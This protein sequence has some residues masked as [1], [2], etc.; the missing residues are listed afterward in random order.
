MLATTLGKQSLLTQK[1]LQ[2]IIHYSP[3]TGIFTWA[4]PRKGIAVT[5]K[6]GTLKPS[7]YIVILVK[8]K[9][10][11]AH[12]L[13]WLYMT[14]N[15]P[16]NEIDHINGDRS[17]NRF[18]NLREATK[19]QNNWN[20]KIRKDSKTGVKNVLHYPK[21]GLYYVKITANKV[22][23][24]FGPYKT[25]QEAEKVAHEKRIQI[26]GNFISYQTNPSTSNSQSE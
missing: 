26:H 15:W 25:L 3:E 6:V 7:G 13:A 9:L 4:R 18:C 8:A 19:A 11:R 16:E 2:N 1:D 17:D 21:W 20:R 23:H 22:S 24:S 10:Y 14:G 5:D 12:R